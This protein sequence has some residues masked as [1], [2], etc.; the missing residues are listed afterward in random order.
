LGGGAGSDCLVSLVFVIVVRSVVG[1]GAL[2]VLGV[3]AAGADCWQPTNNRLVAAV[4]KNRLNLK[5][6]VMVEKLLTSSY[7]LLFVIRSSKK[8]TFYATLSVTICQPFAAPTEE[9]QNSRDVQTLI[10]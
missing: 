2:E 9:G 4:V 5:A 10:V 1:A 3:A 8:F 7:G 6:T